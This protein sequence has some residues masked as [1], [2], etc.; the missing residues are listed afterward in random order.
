MV[1]NCK[2]IFILDL[3]KFVMNFSAF[4]N[5]S[6]QFIVFILIFIYL[7]KDRFF[8]IIVAII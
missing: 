8:Q 4:A 6:L 7:I 1:C 2:M 5:F 3:I